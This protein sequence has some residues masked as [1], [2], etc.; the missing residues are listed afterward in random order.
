MP[1][2]I[3]T[4]MF[5][6][7]SLDGNISAESFPFLSE[8]FFVNDCIEEN[9]RF[10][11]T[12]N[13]PW[14]INPSN[15]TVLDAFCTFRYIRNRFQP[16]TSLWNYEKAMLCSETSFDATV[17]VIRAFIYFKTQ[18]SNDCEVTAMHGM[19]PID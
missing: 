1:D 5:I 11:A 18:T 15:T 6:Q 2:Q 9:T 13:F 16:Q 14:E 19:K 17:R 7:Y 4:A 12:V 8:I 10:V 3:L